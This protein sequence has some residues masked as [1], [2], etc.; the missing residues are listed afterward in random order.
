MNKVRHVAHERDI[1]I[2][3]TIGTSEDIDVTPVDDQ[4]SEDSQPSAAE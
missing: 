1:E 2:M 3:A 4:V